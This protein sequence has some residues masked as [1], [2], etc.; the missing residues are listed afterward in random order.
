MI[1]IAF[2][3]ETVDDHLRDDFGRECARP[4]NHFLAEV[5]AQHWCFDAPEVDAEDF[6]A[7]A[8]AFTRRT[9]GE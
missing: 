7:D 1:R 9:A 6:D 4:R 3:A 2:S 5:L 8:S